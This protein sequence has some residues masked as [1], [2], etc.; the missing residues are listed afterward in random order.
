MLVSVA[1]PEDAVPVAAPPDNDLHERIGRDAG[2][3]DAGADRDAEHRA[4]RGDGLLPGAERARGEV[5]VEHA[6]TERGVD[7]DDGL[8]G[9]G[10]GEGP[11]ARN[12]G[13]ARY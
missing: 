8:P 9:I 12:L 1:E 4:E 11:L 2:T 3:D 6:W 13:L 10:R 7:E 5:G